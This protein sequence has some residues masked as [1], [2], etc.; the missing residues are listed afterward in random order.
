MALWRHDGQEAQRLVA[1][2]LAGPHAGVAW[3]YRSLS[4]RMNASF[5]AALD[6]ALKAL[7]LDNQS[8]E[9]CFAVS[10]AFLSNREIENA[11]LAHSRL[12]K[13]V[14]RDP[15]GHFFKALA[16]VLYAECIANM[17]EDAN[18]MHMDFRLTPCARAAS[19]ILDGYPQLAH[20]ELNTAEY[21]VLFELA[22]GLAY[23]STEDWSD[24]ESSLTHALN[25]FSASDPFIV[26]PSLRSLIAACRSATKPKPPR[27]FANPNHPVIE[28]AGGRTTFRCIDTQGRFAVPSGKTLNIRCPFCNAK[29]IATS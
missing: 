12:K 13:A 19:R 5:E 4:E 10:V 16:F 1:D 11:L 9:C 2:E 26:S 14:V 3:A 27:N 24:A 7:E 21:G 22:S 29:F 17:Q 18:G 23:F 8:V 15:G 6:S 20:G 25:G 28:S